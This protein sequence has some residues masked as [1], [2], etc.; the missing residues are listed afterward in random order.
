MNIQT[1]T[2]RLAHNPRAAGAPQSCL[3]LEA[4]DLN[5]LIESSEAVGLPL[6]DSQIEEAVEAS[7]ARLE[8]DARNAAMSPTTEAHLTE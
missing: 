4:Q 5:N 2:E 3:E 7:L 1:L 8:H 6:N